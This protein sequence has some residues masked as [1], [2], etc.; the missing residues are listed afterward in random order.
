[1]F[2]TENLDSFFLVI[3]KDELSILNDESIKYGLILSNKDIEDIVKERNRVLKEYGLVDFEISI[4]KKIIKIFSKSPY[5]L[6]ND[7]PE[8]I[9]YL[10]ETFY[11]VKS[12]TFDILGDEEILEV[13]ERLFNG[14]C[15]GSID[16]LRDKIISHIGSIASYN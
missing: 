7:Y 13:M 11:Y 2:S 9:N 8:Y 15:A 12:E 1:M 10:V 4:I 3:Q 16:F 5:V 14:L 6:Q